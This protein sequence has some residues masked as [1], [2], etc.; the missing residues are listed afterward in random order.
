MPRLSVIVPMYGVERYLSACLDSLADQG[1]EDFEAILVDDGSLDGCGEIAEEYAA[2]DRRFRVVHQVNGGLGNARN[3]GVGHASGEYLAFLDGDDALPP[4]AYAAMLAAIESTGS[5]IVTGNVQCFDN[6]RTWPA[7]WLAKTF[8]VSRRRTHASRFRWLLVD[9]MAQNKLW[10][11][12]FWESCAL[13]FPEGVL[14]ED[15]AL[16]IRAH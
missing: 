12:S 4:N 5:D 10:R 11:R 14:H 9:R 13:R 3:A 7:A 2:R 1:V 15:I 16:V 8:M 6:S